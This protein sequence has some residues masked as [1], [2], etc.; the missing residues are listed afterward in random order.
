MIREDMR[1]TKYN[2]LF[3]LFRSRGWPSST[4]ALRNGAI[5]SLE[6]K[7]RE[8]LYKTKQEN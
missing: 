1:S 8:L 6:Q 7:Q 3:F 2:H 4:F 5:L